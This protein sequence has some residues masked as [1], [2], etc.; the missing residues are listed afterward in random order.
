MSRQFPVVNTASDTFANW[1][2]KENNIINLVNTDVVTTSTNTAGDLTVGNGFVI[3]IF[4]SNTL[5]ATSIRGGNV[6]TP[7]VLLVSSNVNFTGGQ[8]NISTNAYISGANLY[9]TSLNSKFIGNSFFYSNTSQDVVSVVSNATNYSF[10]VNV[11]SG[12]TVTGN[13]TFNNRVNVT[14][15]AYFANT[16]AVTGSAVFSNTIEI[17][18]S[19]NLQSSANIGGALG[20][21]GG[22][23]I[24]GVLNVTG[25]TGL[26]NTISVS[27]N[28][29]FSNTVTVTGL[30]T[31]VNAVATFANVSNLHS[32]SINIGGGTVTGNSTGLYGVY[33]S[34]TINS[35]SIGFLANSTNITV[36]NSSINASI[37]STGIIA[38]SGT[39]YNL[40]VTGSL[41]GT[42]SATGNFIPSPNNVLLIG[43]SGNTFNHIYVTNTYTNSI[44][45]YSG[46]LSIAS[47][48]SLTG[49]MM[50]NSNTVITAGRY[51][52]T[53]GAQAAVD[54]FN[55][56]SY[57]SAEY[58]IQMSETGTT[59]YHVTKLV[60]YHDGTSAYSSEYA[61]MFNNISLGTITT[62][63]SGGN[64]RV[65]V[66]PVTQ[67]VVVKYSKTLITV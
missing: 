1:I 51:N 22:A 14:G 4:G 36:G 30:A 50:I 53:T 57:R 60:A 62:D 26:S 65:L 6:N 34:G 49:E 41:I 39:F 58:L 38:N 16:I 61:Q 15:N 32:T 13:T 10:S 12:F 9:V 46:N 44:S 23:T 24:A 20:V 28:A 8:S 31:F 47:S 48:I 64:V 55:N 40:N 52:F 7:N 56:T 25:A 42:F 33:Y 66:S 29:T 43:T 54:T 21:T 35:S 11:N 45:S 2:S 67:N 27:G 63:V 18:G 37:T 3:G 17:V 59:N 5:V 19:A